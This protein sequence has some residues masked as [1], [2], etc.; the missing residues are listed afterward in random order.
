VPRFG[1]EVYDDAASCGERG[2]SF[3]HSNRRRGVGRTRK[4]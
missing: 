4:R 3:E 2:V 1:S